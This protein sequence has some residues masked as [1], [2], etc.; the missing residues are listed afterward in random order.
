L[1]GIRRRLVNFVSVARIEAD[2]GPRYWR[3]P[4]AAVAALRHSK[5]FENQALPY[6]SKIKQKD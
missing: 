4:V 1:L 5:A 6:L 3:D 2:A